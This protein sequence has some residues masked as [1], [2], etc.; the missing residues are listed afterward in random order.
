M[1]PKFKFKREEI[2]ESA[3]NLVREKGWKNLSTR[4]L[5]EKLGSS[6]RPIYSFFKS[7]DELEEELV[8]KSVD[9][10]Y[11]FMVVHRTGD[12]WIDHGIGYVIFA[13]EEKHL[14]RGSNN[15][16]NIKHFKAYG[17]K[18]WNA[19]TASLSQYLPFKGLSEDQIYKI[20]LTRWLLCHGLAFQVSNPPPKV[21]DDD[22]IVLVIQNGSIAIIEGLKKQFASDG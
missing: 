22:N 2:I 1:P 20:Q 21:W 10:L 6:A 19:C 13:R 17:D 9:L 18:I 5:A 8:K 16:K 4:T 3:L 15:E 14:F 11:D 7:M 12:P